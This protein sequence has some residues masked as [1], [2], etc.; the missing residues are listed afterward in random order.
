MLTRQAVSVG[1]SPLVDSSVPGV[2]LGGTLWQRYS[3]WRS[4]RTWANRS[5]NNGYCLTFVIN[6]TCWPILIA[7]TLCLFDGDGLGQVAGLV[8]VVAL[9]LGDRSRKYLQWD[10]GQHRLEKR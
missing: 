3:P 4:D 8:D 7:D 1:E 9:G 2:R 10:R 5:T 6:F